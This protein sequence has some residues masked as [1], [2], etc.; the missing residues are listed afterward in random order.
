MGNV[1]DKLLKRLHP[2]AKRSLNEMMYADTWASF[3]LHSSYVYD[4]WNAG[5]QNAL[6]DPRDM[7]RPLSPAPRWT[8]APS[9]VACGRSARGPIRLPQIAPP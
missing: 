2:Q 8:A 1:L 7:P 9:G 4:G 3:E 6:N 5:M